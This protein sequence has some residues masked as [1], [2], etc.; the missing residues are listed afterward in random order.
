MSKENKTSNKQQNGN[1]FI[2]D[3][4]RSKWLV[5]SEDEKN[6]LGRPNFACGKIAVRMREMGFEVQTKAESEQAL[7]IFTAL[8]FYK[9]YGKYWAEKMNE[10]LKGV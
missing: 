3:V 5:L 9:E 10:N 7:V 4:I 8:E 2:A 6:I 1:D